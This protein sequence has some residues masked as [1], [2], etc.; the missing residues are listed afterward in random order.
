M[1]QSY[2][3]RLQHL[4]IAKLAGCPWM[5]SLYVLLAGGAYA[6]DPMPGVTFLDTLRGGGLG[7]EMVVIPAGSFQMGDVSSPDRESDEQPVHLVTIPQPFAVSRFEITFDDYGRFA[8]SN[9]VEDEGWG[10]GPRPV[11]NVSWNE[12]RSYA[13]W[14][15]S[16]TGYRYRLLSEA[17]WEYAA[18]A[19][20][21]ARYSW[22]DTIGRNKA[23]CWR[24]DCGD[25]FEFTAPVGSFEPNAFGLY[26][27]HGNVAEWVEDCWNF[28]YRRA[29][30]DGSAWLKGNCSWRGI[31]GGS[32]IMYPGY[33]RSADRGSHPTDRRE[34]TIGFRVART[35]P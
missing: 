8:E 10:R 31:R 2:S 28:H 35:L 26:D 33:L 12:A 22:G 18:R 13:A 19:G 25:P 11:I 6:Q 20:S 21:K 4:R 1:K 15:S 29:P 23:N 34:R 9:E 30:S 16:Q 5:I 27:M 7:P 3:G 14:L 32:W 24:Q 17:E